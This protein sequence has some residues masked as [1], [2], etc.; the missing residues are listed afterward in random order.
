MTAGKSAR[1]ADLKSKISSIESRPQSSQSS[2]GDHG[3]D[4]LARMRDSR[5]AGVDAPSDPRNILLL[6]EDSDLAFNKIG[7]L[8]SRREYS[9]VGMRRRLSRYDFDGQA[10]EEALARAVRCGLLDD[11][12]YADVLVRSRLS[13]GKGLCGIA[14]ELQQDGID[15]ISV[16]VFADAQ[17][18][19]PEE[20]YREVDRALEVLRRKPPHAKNVRASAYRR[21]ISRGYDSSTA[22]S[23]SRIWAEQAGSFGG[24]E[25]AVQIDR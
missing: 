2:L 25:A 1:L 18:K 23:A 5:S 4:R 12:R 7:S 22:S 24:G 15:P 11:A 21:L 8:A 9:L 16:P 19:G 10:I 17:M 3:A 14:R 6:D 20:S 13:Q